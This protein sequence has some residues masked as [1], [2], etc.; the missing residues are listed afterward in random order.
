M[1]PTNTAGKKS[2]EN[3]CVAPGQ[4]SPCA[5]GGRRHPKWRSELGEGGGLLRAARLGVACAVCNACRS[6]RI[7]WDDRRRRIAH[8]VTRG[9]HAACACLDG[10]RCTRRSD[11]RKSKNPKQLRLKRTCLE[12]WWSENIARLCEASCRLSHR[13]LILL[14][15][16]A[17][18][19]RAGR[20]EV[21]VEMGDGMRCGGAQ[22]GQPGWPSE[23]PRGEQRNPHPRWAGAAGGWGGVWRSRTSRSVPTNCYALEV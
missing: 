6:L 8:I 11:D 9:S 23:P 10:C 1:R 14:M 16:V 17:P 15:F 3:Q 22:S 12:L 4:A 18:L 7:Q 21:G 13:V 19:L 5:G 20:S 2:L